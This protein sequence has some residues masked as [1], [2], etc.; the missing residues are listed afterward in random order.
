MSAAVRKWLITGVSSGLGEALAKAV[1]SR[2]EVVIGT[3]RKPEQLAAFEALAPGRAHA[4]ELDL[5][6]YPRVLDV[7]TAAAQRHG[8]ID[9]LVNNAG[10]GL[11][12]ALEEVS[13]REA[14]DQMETNFFGALAAT[15]A[16]LPSMRAKRW[17]HVV[18][19]T[20]MAGFMGIP[21]MPIYSASKF[22]LEGLGAALAAEGGALGIR[23]TNVEPGA[24]RTRWASSNA[25]VRSER[26]IEDYQKTAGAVRGGLEQMDGHQD[27][28]PAKAA[29]AIIA[30]VDAE[31]P[32]LHLPV[33][34]SAWNT[35]RSVLQ[36]T[37]E[38]LDTWRKVSEDILYD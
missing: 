35:Y 21:G 33:H 37:L 10:Y 38:Q 17:G 23:V 28:D 22:A 36:Q 32:P 26:V 6:D 3:L 12:G 19:I 20:S 5:R 13:E 14:R 4:L 27:G 31:Q 30:A 34:P 11:A 16:V 15:Q 9:V 25:I 29:L 24:L 2:G 8:G 7:V 18:N 1:L